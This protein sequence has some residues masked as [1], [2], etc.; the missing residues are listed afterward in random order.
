MEELHESMKTKTPDRGFCAVWAAG[1]C[2]SKPGGVAIIGNGSLGGRLVQD[3]FLRCRP[4]M[5]H[6]AGHEQGGHTQ[7]D[8]E[9]QHEERERGML[10][11][12]REHPHQAHTADPEDRERAGTREIPKPRR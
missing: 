11:E 2:T 3:L 6:G 9:T 8:G 7:A 1:F 4:A 12:H 5:E 10:R